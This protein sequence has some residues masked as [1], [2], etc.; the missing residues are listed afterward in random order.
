[1]WDDGQRQELEEI[2][3]GDLGVEA[4]RIAANG[5]VPLADLGVDSGAALELQAI[6]GQRYGVDLPAST[7]ELSFEQV[8]EMIS[9]RPVAAGRTDNAIW[10]DAPFGLVWRLTNDVRGWPDLFTE[11]S[12]VEVLGERDGTI[13]FRLTTVPDG[14]GSV[15][16]WVSE[17]R[18]DLASRTATAYRVET[19]PFTFM[20]IR[21][22]YDELERGTRLRWRQEFDVRPEAPFG[23][24]AA[25]ERIDR[26]SRQQ[27]SV[28][29]KRVEAASAASMKEA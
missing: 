11:Y 6:V 14:D 19:G 26:T 1:M 17:R 15:W 7:G 3:V 21:W 9:A 28:I 16:S 24:E 23:V 10:I 5:G 4:G 25:V 8:L 18:S 22:D 29:K 2:F 13:R 12:S 27:M 20:R